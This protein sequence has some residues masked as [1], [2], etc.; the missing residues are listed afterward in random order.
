MVSID[1]NFIIFIVAIGSLLGGSPFGYSFNTANYL[2]IAK[3]SKEK[4]CTACNEIKDVNQ[5]YFISRIKAPATECKKCHNKRTN[6]YKHTK[7]GL[8]TSIYFHQI[9]SSKRRNNEN[10]TYTKEDLLNFAVISIEF[11]LLYNDWVNSRYNK[12]LAPTFDRKNDYDGYSFSNFNKWMTWG[13]NKRKGHNDRKNGINNK[14]SK[15]VLQYDLNGCFIKE[16]YSHRDAE[17]QTKVCQGHI[18]KVCNG[19]R[20]TAGGFI[21][22]NKILS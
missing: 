13:D 1:K 9:E 4:R 19:I 12:L 5:F 14:I 11:N 22:K 10:P 18:S 7:R 17:R 15:S 8:I 6:N 20:A 16:Y 2:K 3:M 21:W